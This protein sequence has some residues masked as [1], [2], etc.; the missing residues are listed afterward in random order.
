M[1]GKEKSAARIRGGRRW[2]AGGRKTAIKG[3]VREARISGLLSPFS[4]L[5]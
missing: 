4:G 2:E 5:L 3:D 1:S